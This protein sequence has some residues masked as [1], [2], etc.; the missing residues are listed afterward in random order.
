ETVE[1]DPW[2]FGGQ[3]QQRNGDGLERHDECRE[4]DSQQ[5]A[6]AA[7]AQE[8]EREG[9]ERADQQRQDHRDAGDQNRVE[10]E[11]RNGRAAEGGKVVVETDIPN[12]QE[13]PQAR[14]VRQQLRVRLQRR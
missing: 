8:D 12:R 10:D 7:P 11:R 4:D 5:Q 2:E 1:A 3:K 14:G 6:T 13:G 9:G